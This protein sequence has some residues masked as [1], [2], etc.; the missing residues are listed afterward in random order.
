LAI[1]NL[2]GQYALA[3]APDSL[4]SLKLWSLCEK[5]KED[6]FSVTTPISLKEVQI[7]ALLLLV[8]IDDFSQR[9]PADYLISLDTLYWNS[10]SRNGILENGKSSNAERLIPFM[11]V[12]DLSPPRHASSIMMYSAE[13]RP[14]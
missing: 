9:V 14:I 12:G 3:N 8:V 1:F 11:E 2:L 10:R 7:E 13:L 4:I 5:V 6:V